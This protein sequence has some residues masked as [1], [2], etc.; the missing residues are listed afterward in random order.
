MVDA[1]P[2]IA[3][4]LAA[5]AA[6]GEADA[7]VPNP[8]A[9]YRAVLAA[10]GQP[11]RQPG[12]PGYA[13]A[14]DG[15]ERALADAGLTPQ[16]LVY[17]SMGLETRA[18]T[19][20]I[21]GVAVPG[22]LPLAPNGAVPSTTWGRPVE[23]PVVWLGDGSLAEMRG[24]PVD[25]C[26]ALIRMGSPHLP[27]VFSQ[28]ARAV[29]AVDDGSASQWQTARMFTEAPISSPRAWM[30]RD[31][32]QAA[33]LLDGAPRQGRLRI[34]VAWR[35]V[36]ATT[37]WALIPAAADAPAAQAKQ[38]VVLSAELATSGA[39]PDRAPGSR[40]AAN[41]AL[42]AALAARLRAEPPQRPVL[43]AFL[44]SHYAAQDG[45]RVL[46]WLVE[47]IHRPDKDPDPLA[48]RIEAATEQ[49]AV[50]ER[51]IALLADDGFLAASGDDPFWLRTNLRRVL[52]GRM[53]TLNYEL[54]QV[55]LAITAAERATDAATTA[56]L[57]GRRD[58]LKTRLADVGKDRRQLYERKITDAES[59]TTLRAAMRD[60][61]ASQRDHL[62]AD[63][64]QLASAQRF[65]RA[66]AG[67]TVV[68]HVGV[69]FADATA[70]WTP[71]PFA[72]SS[73][74]VSI[75]WD[76]RPATGHFSKH[77]AAYQQAWNRVAER[78]A[79]TAPMRT[80]D[81]SATWTYDALSTP[82][83]RQ[84]AC[85]VAHGLGLM[86]SQLVTIGDPLPHDEM[87]TEGAAPELAG[88]A[89]PLHAWIG[90]LLGG[91]MPLRTGLVVTRSANDRLI[92]RWSGSRWLG[93]RI[94]R[95][96]PGSEE[97]LG[98]ADG[99]VTFVTD[100]KLAPDVTHQLCG[101][102][103]LP[104]AIANPFGGLFMPQ[105]DG[106]AVE[107][108]IYAVAFAQ[109]GSPD[110]FYNGATPVN[111]LNPR[112]FTGWGNGVY[113]PLMPRDYNVA[114]A[115][116]RLTGRTD[117]VPK[118]TFG[119][120]GAGGL[121]SVT[122]YHRPSKLV[123]NGLFVLGSAE[124]RP[125][126]H[127]VP[128]EAAEMLS[129]DVLRASAHDAGRLNQTR[130]DVLRSKNLV[131]RPIERVNAAGATH[132][133]KAE[134]ARAAGDLP[135]AAAH[136]TLSAILAFR[137]QEPLR[138]NAD[139]LLKAVVFLLLLS[140]PFAFA[141]ERLVF[142]SP[143]I[144]RQIA[145]FS[146]IFIGTFSLLYI[147]H[148]AFAL[149]D[150]PL[151]IFLA[152]VIILLSGFVTAVVMG[153]FK[154]ELKAMQGLSSQA[155]QAGNRNSTT[156]AAVII[157]IAGMRNRPLKTFLT[158]MTVTLLTF[159]ILV[160]ASFESS[161]GVVE[162]WLGKARGEDRIEVHQKS[163][164]AIPDRLVE[165]VA[166]VHGSR[167][168][169]LAR[170]A[171]WSNPFNSRGESPLT[172]LVLEPSSGRT[173]QLA[174]VV[175]LDPREA[176]RLGLMPGLAEPAA[177]EPA[178]LWLSELAANQLKVAPGARLLI[179]GTPFVLA[180]TFDDVQVRGRE[181][182]NGS[183]LTPP[184]FTATFANYPPGADGLSSALEN[185]DITEL[186]YASPA[187]SGF[188]VNSAVRA[189]GGSVNFLALYPKDG[190]VDL[191]RH[192]GEIAQ[193]FNGPV[194][195][196]SGEGARSWFY[197][198]Q[199]AGSG[200]GDLIVPL[201]LGGLIIFSSLLGSIVDRQKEIFTYSALGL[202][203]RDVG[204]L[205]FAE[206]SVIA[207]IGGMGGYL[208][209]QLVSKGL[210]VMADAGLIEIPAFNFSSLS[211][212][213]TIGI[214][215][216][217]VLLS[218]IYPALMA[219]RSANPGV[220]RAWRMPKPDGDK[221]T[222]TFPF[223]VPEKSFGGIVAF[224]AEHFRNHGDA[225]L[226]VF[227]TADVRLFKVDSHR[228]GI[229]AEVSLAPFDLGVFQRFRMTTR[230]SDI[231]GIDEVVVEI[232]RTNGAASA[233]MRGNQAFISDLREQFLVWRSLPQ[234]A[235]N[236]YLAEAGKLV[237]AE[238]PA[239]GDAHG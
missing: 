157:G 133:V 100:A 237:A 1:R 126:G 49:L 7:T 39:V 214:V 196:T 11:N 198:R 69:D 110:G 16:R 123:G 102:S 203:P 183:R 101:R 221:L 129:L 19:F 114:T 113:I 228:I 230:P 146:G 48:K 104:M 174:A 151:I 50:A 137:A 148:P 158:A 20:E 35:R 182:I 25:G 209:G 66:M 165:A 194:Y 63:L 61:V 193:V 75:G 124:D 103:N 10:M 136:E 32:A 177:G 132:L 127:G 170:T 220:N 111:A 65:E 37:V 76:R 204:T 81:Q 29:I 21:D 197:T 89:A 154:H 150:A 5:A 67:L 22:V 218:T 161:K 169:I 213:I 212:L 18:C 77:I 149:A 144:Y 46:Y 90:N 27:T 43:V 190:Q 147:T 108:Q 188:T 42:L 78:F 234:E 208:I 92:A 226:D 72:L 51:R 41:A 118:R 8:D 191:A 199:V 74:S 205:F 4:L 70:A 95:L 217:T 106:N 121:I 2:L 153:K 140:I 239:G 28:G 105:V 141:L 195:G 138:D 236:H 3:L 206:S 184:D 40:Q 14:V 227:A 189:L 187:L 128:N 98:P 145:G 107:K 64:N 178:P 215:M 167:L 131:N 15:V 125:Q 93:V 79:G 60:E 31:A 73:R 6:A 142:G 44:G 71:N 168:E 17:P 33:G 219:S 152:F 57:G 38:T 211:S 122:D 163:F 82:A 36:E 112:I 202:S 225:A 109:N 80:P 94:D 130:L 180:G 119:G 139:D 231:A 135:K 12:S 91:D 200:L 173:M 210:N 171:S 162:T 34:E 166:E 186:V 84:A 58:L 164:I 99:A 56:S 223:T 156:L 54:R 216:L 160:F 53:N 52:A 232:E 143:S 86:G 120:D 9:A 68:A 23:G 224:I 97:V 172:N 207:V 47:K 175:G 235:V 179:R 201:L 229:S 83:R 13:T 24:K 59:F 85:S 55:N 134:A 88:L 45:A 176:Q 96:A 62:R 185:V 233:W 192:A 238:A 30:T 155:H 116:K 159:T 181:N 222:F 115:W 87:P 117:S 26:I